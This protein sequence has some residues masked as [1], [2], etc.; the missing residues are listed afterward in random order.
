MRH[1]VYTKGSTVQKHCPIDTNLRQR[2][3]EEGDV[4]TE[5][6]IGVTVY[7]SRKAKDY[8]YPPEAG[9]KVWNRFSPAFPKD[10]NTANTLISDFWFPDL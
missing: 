2:H 5:A 9:R 7:K 1:R 8:Q 6:E 4:E 10:T 3:R